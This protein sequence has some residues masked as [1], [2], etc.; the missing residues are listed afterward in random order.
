MNI[1]WKIFDDFFLDLKICLIFRILANSEQG[2]L[3]AQTIFFDEF[4]KTTS[5]M[6]VLSKKRVS[7]CVDPSWKKISSIQ[8]HEFSK[9]HMHHP[10]YNGDGLRISPDSKIIQMT[11]EL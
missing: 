8:K 10:N 2:Y 4:F 6:R 9:I 1:V 7:G 5:T 11:A 3:R